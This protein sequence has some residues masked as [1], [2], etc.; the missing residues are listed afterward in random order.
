[1][2]EELHELLV[3]R[4]EKDVYEAFKK[5][6]NAVLVS[7]QIRDEQIE[8]L[9]SGLNKRSRRLIP[10]TLLARMLKEYDASL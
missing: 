6:P 4:N 9:G 3:T 1:M 8:H 7:V 10:F 5:S 2:S